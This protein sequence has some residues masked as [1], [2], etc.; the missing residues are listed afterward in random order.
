M[1][2]GAVIC[3]RR[4]YIILLVEIKRSLNTSRA[5]SMVEVINIRYLN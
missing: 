1:A 5:C 3:F 4:L 2:T